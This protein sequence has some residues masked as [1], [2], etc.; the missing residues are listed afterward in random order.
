MRIA[1]VLA[2]IPIWSLAS[3]PPACPEVKTGPEVPGLGHL[4]KVPSATE[5]PTA[6]TCSSVTYRFPEKTLKPG[7]MLEF[8]VPQDLRDRGV[9]FMILGHRQPLQKKKVDQWDE[10]P[11]LTSV[12]VLGTFGGS[13]TG[14][15]P[16]P[17]WRYWSGNAS[18]ELGAK[19]AEPRSED[20]P[21]M[22]NLYDWAKIGHRSI[23]GEGFSN[24]PLMPQALRLV[25]MG[26]DPVLVSEVTL[27]VSPP[28]AA[29]FTAGIFSKGTVF[30]APGKS[31]GPRF[32]GGQGDAYKGTFPGALPLNG[33]HGE[34]NP[35]LPGGWKLERGALLIPIPKGRKLASVD[36]A[37]GDS[38]PDGK[39][40]S[41]GGW[42]IQGW[43]KLTV[44]LR[45]GDGTREALMS[46][47][48]VPPEGLL[49]ASPT[50]CDRISGDDEWLSIRG[51]GD[52]VYVM[53][54]RIGYR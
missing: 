16:T 42:G 27:K 18:G 37:C 32:G 11:G 7:D 53:G 47:E 41:D 34:A 8:E 20:D 6:R 31:E 50:V 1:V 26:K 23:V 35:E 12:Q 17:S 38:H 40:N 24:A 30:P 29:T 33:G 14:G 51:E 3:G 46:R 43:G 19:Y 2:L 4:L 39:Q 10:S 28:P 36:I 9:A 44:E 15:S 13:P 49:V 52:T 48:N 25:S 22:E 5:K 54:V 45:R 21:E